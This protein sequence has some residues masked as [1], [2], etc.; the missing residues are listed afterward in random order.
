MGL[1]RDT[2]ADSLPVLFNSAYVPLFLLYRN[3]IIITNV[4][5]I[6]YYRNVNIIIIII[7]GE[8]HLI[9]ELMYLSRP[10]GCGAGDSGCAE[11]GSCRTCA[12]EKAGNAGHNMDVSN[13]L[14]MEAMQYAP[15]AAPFE[16]VAGTQH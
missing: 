2:I 7:I 6:H 11:C 16:L 13:G 4:F 1:G 8:K 15:E 5:F 9:C 14:L 10:C 3:I 12:G